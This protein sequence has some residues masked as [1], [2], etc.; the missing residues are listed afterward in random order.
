[1]SQL[2]DDEQKRLA[3]EFDEQLANNGG[4]LLYLPR[5]SS[6]EISWGVPVIRSRLWICPGFRMEFDKPAPSWW[7]RLWQRW[8]LG[9]R[10]E[11]V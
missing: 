2:P 6:Q 10:W 7:H 3:K 4:R 1:M 11:E 5:S 8:L 9:W